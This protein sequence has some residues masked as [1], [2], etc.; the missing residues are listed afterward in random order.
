[1]SHNPPSDPK[2]PVTF[3]LASKSAQ[4]LAVIAAKRQIRSRRNVSKQE[5]FEEAI[6]DFI[7]KHLPEG[8]GDE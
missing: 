8:V 1:M 5:M 6:A 2:I 3:R 4:A 7:K